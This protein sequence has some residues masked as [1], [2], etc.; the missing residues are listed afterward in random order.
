MPRLSTSERAVILAVLAEG[1]SVA[2][3][4]RIT[5]ADKEAILKLLIDVSAICRSV[6]NRLVRGLRCRLIEADEI[7]SFV[8]TKQKRVKPEDVEKGYGDAWLWLATDIDTK[9]IVSYL[10]ADRGAESAHVFMEDL[11]ARLTHRVQINTDGLLAYVDAVG[12]NFDNKVDL[13]H[14]K[15]AIIGNPDS[16]ATVSTSHAERLNL[17]IRMQDRRFTRKTNGFSKKYAN[18]CASVDFHVVYYNFIR[19]HMSLDVTPAMEAKITDRVWTYADLVELLERKERELLDAPLAKF[20][21]LVRRSKD[22]S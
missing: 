16:S 3:T 4:A 19:V 7:W 9:L 15:K 14:G 11:A 18:H 2:S 22:H 1:N 10:V 20:R 12:H 17:T 5:G 21:S 13:V 6:H 8:H